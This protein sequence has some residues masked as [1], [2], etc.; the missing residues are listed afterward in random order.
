MLTTSEKKIS[1]ESNNEGK[2]G[3]LDNQVIMDEKGG[4]VGKEKEACMNK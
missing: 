4:S 1:K 2:E 3:G